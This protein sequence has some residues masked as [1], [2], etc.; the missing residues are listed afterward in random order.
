MNV[1]ECEVII[2]TNVHFQTINVATTLVKDISENFS[3]EILYFDRK[4]YIYI[5]NLTF[6]EKVFVNN[7]NRERARIRV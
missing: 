7:N 5:Y 2:A 4:Y 1:R 6:K 3:N